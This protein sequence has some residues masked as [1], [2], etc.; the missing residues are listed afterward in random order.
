MYD[1]S[2]QGCKL[3]STWF[4]AIRPPGFRVEFEMRAAALCGFGRIFCFYSRI[5]SAVSG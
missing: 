2:F 4:D 1:D 5:V 3:A